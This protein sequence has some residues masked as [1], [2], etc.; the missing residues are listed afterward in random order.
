MTEIH[1]MSKKNTMNKKASI[2]AENW[3]ALW[4]DA[5]PIRQIKKQKF[6]IPRFQIDNVVSTFKF[7]HPL[8]L[9]LLAKNIFFLE[10]NC[11]KFTAATVRLQEPRTTALTFPSGSVVC[12]GAKSVEDS[13][14]AAIYYADIFKSVDNRLRIL[15]QAQIQNIV[16]SAKCGFTI[17]LIEIAQRFGVRTSFEMNVFPG[18][19]FRFDSPQIVFLVFRSGSV[20]ITGANSTDTI[21]RIFK[22]FFTHILLP[23]KDTGPNAHISNSAE[24]KKLFEPY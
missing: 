18:L 6:T 2:H 1:E 10:Y 8:N 5:A 11:A 4:K 23:F 9:A 7:N 17:K 22:R 15:K 21:T 20:V 3:D 14:R 19:V 12:T 16:A 24:Y 13:K